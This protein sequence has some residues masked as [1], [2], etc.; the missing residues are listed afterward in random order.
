MKIKNL[1]VIALAVAIMPAMMSA[2][3]PK[4]GAEP[5]AE[6]APV[7]AEPEA[8]P[9]IT[10]ECVVNVSLFHESVKNKQYADAYDPWWSVY[11]T[12]PNANKSVYSDGAKIVEALFNATSDPAEKERLAK[13]AIE[14]QDKRIKYFGNDAKYPKAYILGEKGLAYLDFY[15]DTSPV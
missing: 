7:V 2:K 3:K 6:A 12:C 8:E 14:M 10:E 1:L 4:K 9:T 5:A 13:L 15:G 11:T